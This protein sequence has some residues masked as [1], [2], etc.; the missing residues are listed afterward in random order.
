MRE[1]QAQGGV[2]VGNAPAHAHQ[3]QAHLPQAHQPEAGRHQPE[4]QL[5][6][7]LVVHAARD[8]GIPVVNG[9]H[10]GE[11]EA[12]EHRGVEMADDPVAV[13]QVQV[14]GHR[15]QDGAGEAADEEDGDRP[16]DE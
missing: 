10:E 5:A 4:V 7:R 2:I 13:V 15:R 6:Q 14:G 16:Q 8:L 12:A 11:D 1:V 9:R 3:A